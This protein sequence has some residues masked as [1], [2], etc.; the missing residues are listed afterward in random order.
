MDSYVNSYNSSG[1]YNSSW[2]AGM[3]S[4]VNSY[5]SSGGVQQQLGGWDGFLC[6]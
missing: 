2:E 3:D 6:E 4:Y 1:G 5:N